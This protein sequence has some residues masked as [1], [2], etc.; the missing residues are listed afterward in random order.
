LIIAGPKD[1]ILARK[2]SGPDE[3]DNSRGA[4]DVA[5]VVPWIAFWG[6]VALDSALAYRKSQVSP[7]EAAEVRVP[8]DIH[9]PSSAEDPP[10]RSRS[11]WSV[12]A[13]VA[14]IGAPIVALFGPLVV[15]KLMR[16][17]KP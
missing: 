14:M 1:R 11:L 17:R 8:P 16:R 12:G 2:S 13:R 4:L 9:E 15:N 7:E 10:K 5:T 3:P 6:W